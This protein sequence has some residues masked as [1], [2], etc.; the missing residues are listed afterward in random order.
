[1]TVNGR[2]LSSLDDLAQQIRAI[3]EVQQVEVGHHYE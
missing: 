2:K 3:E 1:M